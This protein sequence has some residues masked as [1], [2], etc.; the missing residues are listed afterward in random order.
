MLAKTFGALPVVGR[1]L[2]LDNRLYMI[3]DAVD[4]DGIYSISLEAVRP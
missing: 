1:S 3:T 2:S 4:E